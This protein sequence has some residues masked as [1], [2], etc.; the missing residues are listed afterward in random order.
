[1]LVEASKRNMI[2][3]KNNFVNFAIAIFLITSIY[4]IILIQRS[5]EIEDTSPD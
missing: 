2:F 4:L 5:A 1:M 3:S